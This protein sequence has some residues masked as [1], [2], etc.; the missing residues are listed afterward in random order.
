[1]QYKRPATDTTAFDTLVTY[2]LVRWLWSA[3][4][5]KLTY[6]TVAGKVWC[7]AG[8]CLGV[9][10]RIIIITEHEVTIPYFVHKIIAV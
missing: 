10:E 6:N 4:A 2:E 7:D 1:V 3:I 8:K 9:D 5:E